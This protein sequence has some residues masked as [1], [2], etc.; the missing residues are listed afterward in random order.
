MSLKRG[1]I[2]WVAF[3]ERSPRGAEIEKTR[4]CVI[5]S[6]ESIN[7]IRRTVVVIP[8]A[9][10]PKPAPPIALSVVSAGA[11]SVAVCDQVQ[12]ID[13]RRLRK[14]IGQLSARDIAAIEDSLRVILGL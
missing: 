8:L 9:S 7:D 10:S 11:D 3:P 6:L 1:G 2:Y 14:Q 4:P 13:K 5:L 12:V